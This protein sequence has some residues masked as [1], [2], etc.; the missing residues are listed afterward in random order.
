MFLGSE[1]ACFEAQQQYFDRKMS[2]YLFIKISF[3]GNKAR[4][5]CLCAESLIPTKVQKKDDKLDKKFRDVIYECSFNI[6]GV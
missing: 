1:H 3:Y 2:F 6:P 5:N 4:E